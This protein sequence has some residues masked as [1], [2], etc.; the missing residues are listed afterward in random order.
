MIAKPGLDNRVQERL[1][2]GADRAGIPLRFRLLEGVVDGDGEG[3]V[4]LLSETLHGQGH[5]LEKECLGFFLASVA[6]G[7]SHQ[8]L[9][10]RH[11]ERGEK[12]GK[13]RSQGTAQP[14]IE[15]VGQIGVADVV[16][17]GR[18]GG[19]QLVNTDELKSCILLTCKTTGF[20]SNRHA[21]DYP[22]N[23]HTIVA[24][25]TGKWVHIREV[26][27]HRNCLTRKCGDGL[28][29]LRRPTSDC[30]DRVCHA[31]KSHRQIHPHR[32]GIGG[33]AGTAIAQRLAV[34]GDPGGESVPLHLFASF[35]HQ[36]R[37]RR[38]GHELAGGEEIGPLDH[39]VFLNTETKR[40]SR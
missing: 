11:G 4:R 35:L 21:L 27:S 19:Y 7:R 38:Q 22:F 3:R 26:P 30:T 23:R 36:I 24:G 18:V 6:I 9:G 28:P 25:S 29:T 1:P 34:V 14:D 13:N 20:N 2:A 16:V 5:P 37:E 33:R 10:F 31:T 32:L 39:P 40:P 15:E 17:I 8:L 12:V